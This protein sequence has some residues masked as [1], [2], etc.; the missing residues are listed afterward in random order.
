MTTEALTWTRMDSP[1]GELSLAASPAGLATVHFGRHAATE[2]LPRDHGRSAARAH[3]DAATG[4]LREYF[5]RARRSFELDV[6]PEGTP[7]DQLVWA[8]LRRIPHGATIS[9]G[10]LARRLDRPGA[11]RAVG[12]ANGRNPIAIIVPCHRVIASDGSLGG[13]AGGLEL[14][15]ALLD[16]EEAL[17]ADLQT[18]LP[19]AAPRAAPR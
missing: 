8:E 6:A 14:K 4:Q 17:E 18:R 10:E 19:L 9:Y 1:L 11:A 3:L 7:F 12:H 16:L 13:Y 5:A 2:R 15:R